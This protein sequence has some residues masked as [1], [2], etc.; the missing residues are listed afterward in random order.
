MNLKEFRL[1]P[2]CYLKTRNFIMTTYLDKTLK[3]IRGVRLD[4][5]KVFQAQ[6]LGQNTLSDFIYVVQ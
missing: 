5:R 2:N 3:G 1:K 4:N 6:V